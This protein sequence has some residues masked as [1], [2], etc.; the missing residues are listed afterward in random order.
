MKKEGVYKVVT[1]EVVMVTC[2][3]LISASEGFRLRVRVLLSWS[4]SGDL[5]LF[6]PGLE[7]TRP[8]QLFREDWEELEPC[9]EN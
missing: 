2:F 8:L 9:V 1:T 5:V 4:G 6:E 7:F 3:Q